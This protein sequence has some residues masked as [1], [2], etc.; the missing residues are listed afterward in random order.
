MNSQKIR[1][2]INAQKTRRVFRNLFFMLVLNDVGFFVVLRQQISS[3]GV[4]E[5]V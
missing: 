3:L 1:P 5:A 4:P 2:T